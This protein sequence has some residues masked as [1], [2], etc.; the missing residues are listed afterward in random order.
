MTRDVFRM[1]VA[2]AVGVACAALVVIV[3]RL[4]LG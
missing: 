4:F 2:A 1:V 3:V